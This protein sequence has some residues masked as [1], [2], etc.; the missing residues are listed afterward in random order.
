MV[1]VCVCM[2]V[3]FVWVYVCGCVCVYGCVCMCACLVVLMDVSCLPEWINISHFVQA[4]TEITVVEFYH[5]SALPLWTLSGIMEEFHY[6]LRII[7]ACKGTAHLGCIVMHMVANSVCRALDWHA[8]DP[9]SSPWCGKGFFFQSQLSVQ[10]LLRCLYTP[11]CNCIHEHLC[12]H[13][14]SHSPCQS[15][16]Y[17]GNTETTSMHHKL[18][19][20]TLSQLAFPGEG[21]QNLPWEKSYGDIT[22]V[23]K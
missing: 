10:T 14:R 16:M 7:C 6:S 12:T 3:W 8:T 17:Y 18:G 19:S 2:C 13:E 11:V 23:K 5:C 4:Q 21:N 1:G 22:V 15:L 20:L 9:G